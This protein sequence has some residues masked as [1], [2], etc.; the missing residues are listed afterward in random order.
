LSSVRRRLAALYGERAAL[1]VG[2]SDA[3]CTVSIALP[4]KEADLGSA[5]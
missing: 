5:A 3:G 1:S 2:S 4:L